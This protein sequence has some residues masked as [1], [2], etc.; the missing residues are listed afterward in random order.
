M[1]KGSKWD[2][3]R[4]RSVQAFPSGKTII[5]GAQKY[6]ARAIMDV[7][8]VREANETLD[9]KTYGTTLDAGR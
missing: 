5:M 1:L 9:R 3:W 7:W 8:V 6:N 2:T 4:R